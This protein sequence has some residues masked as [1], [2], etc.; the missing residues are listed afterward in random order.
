MCKLQAIVRCVVVGTVVTFV[1]ALAAPVWAADD[2]LELSEEQEEFIKS[3]IP[4]VSEPTPTQEQSDQGFIIYWADPT[5]NFYTNVGPTA[6]DLDRKPLIRTPAGEDEPLLLSVWGLRHFDDATV[7]VVDPFFETTVSAVPARPG[8]YPENRI[9][10][11]YP[12]NLR[13]IPSHPADKPQPKLLGKL[14]IPYFI[15][16]NPDLSVEPGLNAFFW[17]NVFVPAGTGPGIYEG[18]VELLVADKSAPQGESNRSYENLRRISLP[19]TVEVLPVKLPRADIAY[20][21]WFRGLVNGREQYGP[22]Y[23]TEAMAMAYYRDMARHGHTSIGFYSVES[24]CDEQGHVTLE[25]RQCTTQVEMMIEAGLLHREIPFLWLGTPSFGPE[26][27]KRYAAELRAEVERRG[28]PDPL[29]YGH[30]EPGSAAW[31]QDLINHFNQRENF[32]PDLRTTTAIS[33]KSVET[34]GQYLDVW[35]VHNEFPKSPQLYEHFKT[36]AASHNAE[37]WEYDCRHRGTN[38]VWHR[39]FAGIYTWATGLKGNFIWC[40][41][42]TFTWGSTMG[43]AWEPNFVRVQPCV[44]GPIS[45]VGWEARREGIEDYRYLRQIEKIAA[46]AQSD[47]ADKV[48]KWLS[49]LRERVVQTDIGKK[50]EQPWDK[51]DLWTECPQF[52]RGEFADIRDEAIQFL[53]ELEDLQS[54][55]DRTQRQEK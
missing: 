23:R 46:S 18:Q 51:Y 42:E 31:D 11:Y 5:A 27:S 34:W 49:R 17:I 12:G 28:W 53:L 2:P 8:V 41:G 45:S 47:R 22:Q 1:A 38:P 36:L 14:G 40:Y 4:Q 20:G 29:Q 26:Q 33:R 30:D 37:L 19:F 10:T 24:I 9:A 7:R 43:K 6:E 35:I 54:N 15:H 21:A 25:G 16:P 48:R 50:P 3:L 55:A 39:Y 13:G 44:Y 52:E 32:R